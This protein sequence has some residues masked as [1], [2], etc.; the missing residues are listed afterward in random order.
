MIH[1]VPDSLFVLLP[2]LYG[3]NFQS[4]CGAVH[5]EPERALDARFGRREDRDI[6]PRLYGDLW[7][8][9]ARCE[10]HV[11][12]GGDDVRVESRWC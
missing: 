2:A 5:D 7:R 12:A 9:D 1:D 6:L 3:R 10:V 4:C 8:R 11:W